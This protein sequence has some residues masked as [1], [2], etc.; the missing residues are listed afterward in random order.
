MAETQTLTV[1][2]ADVV[3]SRAVPDREGFGDDLESA[4]LEANDAHEDDVVAPAT[5]LK[6]VDEFGCVLS[7]PAAAYPVVRDVQMALHPE[8]AR[9]AVV[10]G[11]VDVD[12]GTQDVREMDGPAFHRADTLLGELLADE[13]H[14]GV[15]SGRGTL[16]AAASAAGDMA[17]SVREGWTDRQLEVVRAYLEGG[18][19][20]ATAEALGVSQQAVS[21]VLTQAEYDRVARAEA[22]LQQAMA[23]ME[24]DGLSSFT[25]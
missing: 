1:I 15:E 20:Q 3:A 23:A 5:T 16:D 14:F 6:G 9:Y 13:A 19:Q 17:L 25:R 10:H 12:A 2:L 21:R 7:S 11:A 8:A 22:H 4:L 18:T 24:G